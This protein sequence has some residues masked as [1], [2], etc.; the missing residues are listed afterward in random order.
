[1]STFPNSPRL[2]KGGLVLVHPDSGTVQKIIVLQYNRD[3]LTRTSQLQFA[4]GG[5]R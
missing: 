5:R 2:V 4:E 1:M 3:T